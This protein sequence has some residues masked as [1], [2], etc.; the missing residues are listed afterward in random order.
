MD[1]DLVRRAQHGDQAAFATIAV[2]TYG[3]LQQLAYG[4]LRDR[5]L[6]EDATQQAMLVAW[7]ELP[8]LR[9]PERFEAWTYRLLVN[10][11]HAEGR[12]ASR[13]L[14]ALGIDT[15]AD[16]VTSD[17]TGRVA[18]RDQLER[19]FRRLSLDHRAVVVLRHYL[20]L[21]MEDVAA[22]LD[23]PVGTVR[24]RLHRAMQELR[25]ALEADTRPA[26]RLESA[27]KEVAR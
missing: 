17:E 13:W 12:K 25:A 24:S 10:A 19:G 3:R 6:A 4:M 7:R 5:H 18:D 21:S 9:D 22:V 16:P 15:P 27:P 14:P 1:T 23:I 26:P 11:C 20:D 8:R 2:A